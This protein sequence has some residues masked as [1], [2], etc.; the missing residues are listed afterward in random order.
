MSTVD[1]VQQASE[2]AQARVL[3]RLY[4]RLMFRGRA[5]GQQKLEMRSPGFSFVLALLFFALLGLTALALGKLS[6]VAFAGSLH[7]LTF[8]LVGI[9]LAS[10]T[11]T[12]LFNPDEAEV[13]LHRPIRPR[14]LLAAKVRVIVLVTFALACVLNICGFI[15]G[16]LRPGS[17]WLFVPAH[18][19]SVAMEVLFC[20]SFVVLAYNLCLRWFGRER[21]D[22]LMTSVQVVV[23][24]GAILGGQLAPRM[25]DR[26][27][28]A[29]IASMPWLAVLPP[30]WFAGLDLVLMGRAST[31][32]VFLL[33]LFAVLATVLTTWLGVSHLASTYEQGLVS[34]NEAD[35]G[36]V[37][38]GG[39]RGRFV[40]RLLRM[41]LLRFW[42]QDPVERAAFSLT[43]AGLTRARGVKLRVYPVLAQFLVYPVI[44]FGGGVGKSASFQ[45]SPYAM[46]FAGVFIAMMPGMV[47]DRLRPA[48][49]SKAADLFWYAPISNPSALFHG[50]RKAAILLLC[51]PA[52]LLA[53]VVGSIWLPHRTELLLLVPGLT[54]VPL[55]SLL[56]GIGTVFVPFSEPPEVQSYN[57]TGCF[58]GGMFMLGSAIIG[59]ITGFAWAWGWFGWLLA[60][61]IPTVFVFTLWLR[62]ALN[63]RKLRD[64]R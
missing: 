13:L 60:V 1:P 16:A 32:A 64:E 8:L 23:A 2:A 7:A 52:F 46:A 63:G 43:L 5:S 50:T 54:L 44:F 21:L 48:E 15:V 53:I 14:A 25:I 40:A 9:N 34:L 22:N 36:A 20:T 10:T 28:A 6:L 35:P 19:V 51:V 3:R 49:D 42:L 41:P 59:G 17:S 4:L 12:L 39:S 47:M 56:S 26:F 29:A 38:P 62:S 18:L 30:A 37:K 11:G 45:I 31:P 55:F 24:M 57:T 58:L 33:G 27:D 61:E